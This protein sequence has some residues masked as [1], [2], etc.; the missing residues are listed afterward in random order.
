VDSGGTFSEPIFERPGWRIE[1]VFERRGIAEG[2]PPVDIYW[3][4]E[5]S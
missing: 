2:R 4:R 1:T 5:N 3:V